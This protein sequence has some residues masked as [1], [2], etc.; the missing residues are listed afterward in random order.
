MT[1]LQIPAIVPTGM[2]EIHY[3]THLEFPIN[4]LPYTLA[5]QIRRDLEFVNP[6]VENARRLKLYGWQDIPKQILM[7]EETGGWIRIPR[8]YRDKLEQ[9]LEQYMVRA[10]WEH[11]VTFMQ[12]DQV[13]ERP[14]LFPLRPH[15]D[16][17]VE[18]FVSAE[19]GV[20]CAP[21]G[22]GKTCAA[23]E[24][25]S[26][27]SAKAC[28]IVNTTN[29]ARQWQDRAR[30]YLGVEA[31]I[32]GDDQWDDSQWLTIALNQTLYARREKLREDGWFNQFDAVVADEVHHWSSPTFLE[33]GNEFPA[34]YRIGLSA[35][36]DRGT[37]LYPLITATFGPVIHETTRE[38]LRDAGFL[39][40]PKIVRVETG[41]DHPYWPTTNRRRNNYAQVIS[42][43]AL[44]R[45][46]ND[47]I[48]DCVGAEPFSANLV[49]SKRL[50]HLKAIR[51]LIAL[52]GRFDSDRLF[53]LTGKESTDERMRVAAEAEKGECVIF[54]TIADEALDIP[55]LD[56]LYL[57]WPTKSAALITQQIGRIERAH[58]AK[59]DAIVFDF[60]DDCPPLKNQWRCRYLEVYGPSKMSVTSS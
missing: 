3:G 22:S 26:V 45:E 30:D 25:L 9:H 32:V 29:I 43:L 15:Q 10:K 54:S 52:R 17:S 41:F 14:G 59:D 48:A 16:W 46:R 5:A 53:M 47:L 13:I 1:T 8:G 50:G 18:S 40:E 44:D 23:L 35:T 39:V 42:A 27:C 51:D 4:D 33:I 36:P 21:P 11:S 57:A 2:L 6:A 20:I 58:P 60:V 38:E 7:Y 49:L 24:G 19:Q 37:G 31:G 34:Q 12:P 55:R 28:V 56:R